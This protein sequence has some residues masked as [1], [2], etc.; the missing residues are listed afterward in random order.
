M[1]LDLILRA[2]DIYNAR[3]VSAGT[4]IVIPGAHQVRDVSVIRTAESSSDREEWTDRVPPVDRDRGG[5]SSDD[6]RRDA[7]EAE[8]SGEPVETPG[9]GE[10]PEATANF[11]PLWPCKGQIVSRFDKDGDPSQQGIMMHVPPGS[12]VKAMEAGTIRL[13]KRVE[14]PPE[15][16]QFGNLVMIFHNDNFVSVYAHLD[17]MNVE[18]GDRVERGQ[19]IGSAGSTGYVDQP[20]CYFQIRYKVKPRDP[21]LFLGE[22]A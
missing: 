9:E 3:Q 22:P 19:T 18:K 7:G 17:K 12:S 5:G 16:E 6:G 21:L 13:A 4:R 20:S 14:K 1:D 8:S 2:N 11:Q 10:A 15:L